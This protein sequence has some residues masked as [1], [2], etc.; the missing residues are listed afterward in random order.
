MQEI[1]SAGSRNALAPARHAS[2]ATS[3]AHFRA[4]FMCQA[5]STWITSLRSTHAPRHFT[6]IHAAVRESQARSQVPDTRG[7]RKRVLASARRLAAAG[8]GSLACLRAHVHRLRP[9][10]TAR[11]PPSLAQARLLTEC[12]E[13]PAAAEV[14]SRLE[15][16]CSSCRQKQ[17]RK[18]I[19]P[20]QSGGYIT[21]HGPRLRRLR[22]HS[23]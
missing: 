20:S 19:F 16:D 4:I 5:T 10:F 22:W 6:S 23:C 3:A 2:I 8:Q 9:R 14:R 18:R 7:K 11:L 21:I 1:P 13:R 15:S 17:E 12:R